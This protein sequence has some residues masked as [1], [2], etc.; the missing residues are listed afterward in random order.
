MIQNIGFGSVLGSIWE[1]FGTV[2]GISGTLLGRLGTLLGRSWGALVALLGLLATFW[3]LLGA[4]WVL[5]VRLLSVL[6]RVRSLPAGFWRALVMIF[7][8]F[9]PPK[10][11]VEIQ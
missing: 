1:R 11:M 5:F 3:G 6:G 10:S 7:K 4:S 2:W 8:S 9:W